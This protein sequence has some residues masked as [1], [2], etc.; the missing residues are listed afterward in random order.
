MLIIYRKCFI[1]KLTYGLIGFYI[2]EI[3]YESIEMIARKV[4]PT[5]YSAKQ[6]SNSQIILKG[7]NI[8]LSYCI[9]KLP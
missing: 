9:C 8:K 7:I 4:I 5:V 3:E 1:P 6:N 2:R